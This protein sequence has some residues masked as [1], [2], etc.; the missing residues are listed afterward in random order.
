M[1]SRVSNF[2]ENTVSAL[3]DT[4]A[5]AP[6]GTRVSRTDISSTV[7][8]CAPENTIP[9]LVPAY[10]VYVMRL[11]SLP[12]AP[13]TRSRP[14]R[15]T[16][17]ELKAPLPFTAGSDFHPSIRV[18]FPPSRRIMPNLPSCVTTKAR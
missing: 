8:V 5:A 13:K 7:M 10:P 1:I 12:L 4:A 3:S 17:R 6:A 2:E 16:S 14:S 11:R 9:I 18:D 15:R